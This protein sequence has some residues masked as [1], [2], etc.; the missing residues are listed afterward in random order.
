M[1]NFHRFS[2]LHTTASQSGS[3]YVP[4]LHAV[5][6]WDA[7]LIGLLRSLT[8]LS[9]SP[10]NNW[11][12]HKVPLDA[13]NPGEKV[14][15]C[16]L[17]QPANKQVSVENRMKMLI[18]EESGCVCAHHTCNHLHGFF[19]IPCN[20]MQLMTRRGQMSVTK[21]KRTRISAP[22]HPLYC[23]KKRKPIINKYV[24]IY[25]LSYYSY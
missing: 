4:Y 2:L 3:P 16:Q 24:E 10:P 20:L 11:V 19:H 7:R 17:T 5:G 25:R 21:Q 22:K 23:T 18:C 14:F 15:F 13:K 1:V 12:A 8:S 6:P 9:S